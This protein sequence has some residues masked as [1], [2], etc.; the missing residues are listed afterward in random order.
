MEEKEAVK[1]EGE[2]QDPQAAP[3]APETLVGPENK[4]SEPAGAKPAEEALIAGDADGKNL[5]SDEKGKL[6]EIKKLRADRRALREENERLIADRESRRQAP[7]PDNIQEVPEELR[8][9]QQQV[10]NVFQEERAKEHREE[11]FNHI[12]SQDD[13]ATKD[14]LNEIGELMCDTGL[15]ILAKTKPFQ[16]AELALHEWRR[17]KTSKS[18]K[19]SPAEKASVQDIP[20]GGVKPGGGASSKK[21]WSRT[22]IKNMS[23]ADYE[24]NRDELLAASKEGRIK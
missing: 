12:L 3:A 6:F 2:L 16:A 14:D 5:P 24:K 17:V 18:E 8:T 13:V 1:D 20:K 7:P 15:D 21:L 23:D 4:E 9:I 11:A 22:D 19:A 10:R